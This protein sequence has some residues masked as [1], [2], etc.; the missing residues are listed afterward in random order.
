MENFYSP[1]VHYIVTFEKNKRHCVYYIIE[2]KGVEMLR[3]FPEESEPVVEG[4]RPIYQCVR[5]VGQAKTIT[6]ALFFRKKYIFFK[7]R[8]KIRISK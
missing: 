3:F 4:N 2:K 6:H 7:I 5:R 8:K 1:T